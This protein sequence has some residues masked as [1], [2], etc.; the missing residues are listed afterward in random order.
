MSISDSGSAIYAPYIRNIEVKYPQILLSGDNLQLTG[1]I[2]LVKRDGSLI[3][4]D[5]NSY[6]I[7]NFNDDVE[8]LLTQIVAID[9]NFTLNGSAQIIITLPNEI[10]NLYS[11]QNLTIYLLNSYGPRYVPYYD[12]SISINIP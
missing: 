8:D 9:N 6:K 10:K 3:V 1:G 11:G 5:K 4:L 12:P 7:L 2:Y